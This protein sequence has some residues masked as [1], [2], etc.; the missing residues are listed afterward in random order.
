MENKI[1]ILIVD[2]E[3]NVRLM[4][5]QALS[6]EDYEVRTAVNGEDG[7]EKMAE[8]NADIVLLDMKLP[9]MEGM[10]V[11]QEIRK[12]SPGTQ[13]IM[14][15]AYGSVETAVEAMKLGA[16]DYLRKP[17]SAGQI[18]ELIKE[19]LDRRALEVNQLSGSHDLLQYAK[20]Q[21]NHCKYGEALEYLHRA[22]AADPGKPEPFNLLGIVFEMQ[23]KFS[24]AQ[25]MYR[26]ALGL[27]ANYKPADANL[28]RISG[29][30][31]TQR[32][33]DFGSESEGDK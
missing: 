17:F 16:I 32:G 28:T 12:E 7:L 13:V 3:K 25:R 20:Y 19:V 15:T 9:G 4:L 26:A 29:F 27:D 1:Q 10:Q 21:L 8:K 18:R 22:V 31:Y 11:L 2:D 24:D 33:I 6:N 30:P 23:G 5:K 14:I